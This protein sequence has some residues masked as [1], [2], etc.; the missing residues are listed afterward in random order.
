MPG[1]PL[2]SWMSRWSTSP[3]SVSLPQ[4]LAPNDISLLYSLT[5]SKR[6]LNKVSGSLDNYPSFPYVLVPM[7]HTHTHTHTHSLT[8]T[9]THTLSHTHT[10]THTLTHS[11]TH[12]HTH[13]H[14]L[15]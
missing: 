8:H 5:L 1:I 4:L 14:T 12:T 13:T 7:T 3:H 2:K 9:H 6:K 15:T 11:L 10:H